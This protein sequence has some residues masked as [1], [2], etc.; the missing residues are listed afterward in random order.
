MWVILLWKRRR[1]GSSSSS[2]ARSRNISSHL[3]TTHNGMAIPYRD[4]LCG[5]VAAVMGRK[6]LV[7]DVANEMFQPSLLLL[8]SFSSS[9]ASH[10]V[11]DSPTAS[12]GRQRQANRFGIRGLAPARSRTVRSRSS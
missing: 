9:S 1:R 6:I 2:T 5:I 11:D 3:T 7:V 4:H 10:C 12:L 8:R